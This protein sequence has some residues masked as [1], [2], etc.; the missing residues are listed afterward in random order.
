MTA[1]S[2]AP[3]TQPRWKRLLFALFLAS[4]V[5]TV[6]ELA[7]I[8]YLKTFRGYDG[9]HLYEYVFDQYK[10]ILPAPNYADTRGIQHN[11]QGFRRSS[12]VAQHK[13]P[14]TYRIFLMGGSTA[15][16]LGGLWTHIE[17]R[18]PV[19]PNSETIDAFLEREL[20]ARLSGRRVEV[21]NAAITSTWTHHELIYIN[22]TILSYQPDMIL[23]L[24]GF[25]DYFFRNEDHDEFADYAY[26][27]PARVI[28]GDPTLK[29]LAYGGGWWLFRKNAL[30][31]VTGRAL[32]TLSLLLSRQPRQAPIDVPQA[33][34]GLH[35]VFPRS[36]LRMHH[37]IGLILRDE[38]VRAVF[39]LQPLLILERGHKPLTPVEQRLFDFNVTSDRPNAEAFM[40]AAVPFV[41]EE[42]QHMAYELGATYLDLTGIYGATREQ[43]YLD[44]CHLTAHG[45]AI[46]ARYVADHVISLIPHDPSATKRPGGAPASAHPRGLPGS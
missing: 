10:N 28:L 34:A 37:R 6:L 22:Q 33:L 18:Y 21:I 44:Y 20:T 11:A 5:Y 39:M 8:W 43:V 42:E 4:A 24:D 35:D 45:N 1:P 19:I 2:P 23:F 16:G 46:L 25:N 17:S 27:M 36:A 41:R 31:T 3:G 7:A 32:R 30:A 13:P 38:G 40:H 9:Q 26:G 14:G 15:Y 12:D 29:S